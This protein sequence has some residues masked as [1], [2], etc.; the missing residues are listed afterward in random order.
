VTVPES[1]S[2]GTYNLTITATDTSSPPIQRSVI[3]TLTVLHNNGDF[4]VCVSPNSLML[5]VTEEAKNEA[6]VRVTS[7]GIFNQNV[8]LN[9]LGLPAHVTATFDPPA[10]KPLAGSTAN[11][12]MRIN[13]GADAING[14]YHLLIIGSNGTCGPS[15]KRDTTMQRKRIEFSRACV[16]ADVTAVI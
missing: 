6:T 5:N 9:V 2:V 7:I 13:V 8:T 12:I 15:C 14:T 1:A 16:L 11:S 3:V 4:S 10:P